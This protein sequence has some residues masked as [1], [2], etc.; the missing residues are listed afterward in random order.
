MQERA[1]ADRR[2]EVGQR[3]ARRERDLLEGRALP[4]TTG[5][6]HSWSWLLQ[7][8]FAVDVLKCEKCGGRLRIVEIAKK[9]D[10]VARVLGERGY[11]RAPPR[12]P[13]IAELPVSPHGQ[14]RLA[15]K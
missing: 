5:P 8:V 11:A 13:P 4:W 15:F 3:L 1:T 6:L 9:P 12:A 2:T 10:D 14:L 7:R